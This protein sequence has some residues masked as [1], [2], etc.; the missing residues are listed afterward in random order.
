[1]HCGR[2]AMR[3]HEP[4][5][6][7]KLFNHTDPAKRCCDHYNLHKVALGFG[8]IGKWIAVRLIDGDSD[9]VL[10]DDKLAAVTHQHH[11]EKWYTFVKLGPQSMNVCEAEVVLATARKLYDAG[12]RLTDPDHKHGG[13]DVIK[14]LTV[15]DAFAQMQG[16]NTN[17]IMPWEA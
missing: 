10:Y 2:E 11:N 6:Q 5:C 16:F 7:L 3:E 14:R 17:L 4:W 12:L 8:S 15:E 9:G 13:P 1:M